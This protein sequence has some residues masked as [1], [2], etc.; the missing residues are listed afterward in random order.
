[1]TG[2]HGLLFDGWPP[3]AGRSASFP[4]SVLCEGV[5]HESPTFLRWFRCVVRPGGRGLDGRREVAAPVAVPVNFNLP[6]N[7]TNIA[8]LIGAFTSPINETEQAWP[9][10]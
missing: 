6:Q 7:S 10:V 3:G 4:G 1:M 8:H 5:S 9:H 2:E